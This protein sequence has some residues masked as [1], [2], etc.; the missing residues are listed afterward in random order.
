MSDELER[1]AEWLQRFVEDPARYDELLASS[2]CLAVAAFRLAR[3]RCRVRPLPSTTP[4][5]AE[6]RRAAVEIT[7]QRAAP[8]GVDLRA[9][10]AECEDRGFAVVPPNRAA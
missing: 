7:D 2:G 4:T 8:L 3:A 5:H 6:L 9:L 1:P 10:L